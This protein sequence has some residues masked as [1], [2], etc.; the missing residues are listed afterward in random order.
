MIKN[1]IFDLGGVV[2]GRNKSKCPAEINEFFSF[3]SEE[4]EKFP[5]CWVE[6]DRGIF[7]QNQ[8]AEGLAKLTDCSCSVCNDYINRAIQALDVFPYT[9]QLIQELAADGYRL[10]VLSNMS[11]EF[12]TQLL[13]FDVFRYFHGQV[14]SC[15]EHLV[16]PD[17]EFYKLILNRFKLVPEATLFV[18]DKLKNVEA[19]AALNIQTLH[20]TDPVQSCD[21]IR[22]L[23]K[24]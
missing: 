16:K 14:I 15:Y 5:R 11:R 13:T 24:S 10:F 6:F 23:L 4:N 3:L 18:D 22:L 19:A 20:F 7:S 17:P 8:V 21:D 2:A 1:I 9:E 12:Y